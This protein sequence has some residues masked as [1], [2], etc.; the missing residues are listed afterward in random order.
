MFRDEAGEPV[1]LAVVGVGTGPD[2]SDGQFGG[3]VVVSPGDVD[4]IKLTRR[5]AT[6]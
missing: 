5:S 4:R 6:R 1:T 3:G 2:L